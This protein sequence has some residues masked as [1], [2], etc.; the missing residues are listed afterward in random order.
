MLSQSELRRL[1]TEETPKLGKRISK[2]DGPYRDRSKHLATS[3]SESTTVDAR[4]IESSRMH[5]DDRYIPESQQQLS[6]TLEPFDVSDRQQASGP[7]YFD[8]TRRCWN[9]FDGDIVS[10]VS[11]ESNRKSGSDQRSKCMRF[12]PVPVHRIGRS[13]TD[14]VRAGVLGSRKS[15]VT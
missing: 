11:I 14:S 9:V 8:E 4:W 1:A 3:R 12:A 15:S 7:I 5:W 10:A 13:R 2:V 6:R